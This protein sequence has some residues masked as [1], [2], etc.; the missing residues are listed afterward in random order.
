MRSIYVLTTLKPH[1]KS[2]HGTQRYPNIKHE[3]C[4]EHLKNLPVLLHKQ[5]KM[6]K[7]ISIHFRLVV[8]NAL[9]VDLSRV[10]PFERLFV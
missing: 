6:E 5:S 9:R 10:W 7:E 8:Q 3:R 1:H 4:Q 2:Y